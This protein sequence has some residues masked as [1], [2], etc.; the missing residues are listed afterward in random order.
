MKNSVIFLVGV[1]FLLNIFQSKA[2][3]KYKWS[4]NANTGSTMLWGDMADNENPFVKMFSDQSKLSFG[5]TVDRQFTNYLGLQGGFLYARLAGQRTLWSN[6]KPA[7]LGFEGIGLD[8]YIAPTLDFTGL[9]GA[10]EDR[11]ISIYIFGGVGQVHYQSEKM[12]IA[13]DKT[14]NKVGFNGRQSAITIPWGGGVKLRLNDRFKIKFENSYRNLFVDDIDAHIGSGTNVNDIYS[15][16]SVGLDYRFNIPVKREPQIEIEPIEKDTAIAEIDTVEVY[17]PVKVMIKNQLPGEIENGKEYIASIK[18]DKGS[19][20]DNAKLSITAPD[21]FKIEEIES[22]GGTF[23][24]SMGKLV[25]NWDEF[26]DRERLDIKYKLKTDDVQANTYNFKG[27]LIY[28]EQ[29]KEKVKQFESSLK[30]KAAEIIAQD[31][32]D[33]N[34]SVENDNEN[35]NSDVDVFELDN[36]TSAGIEFR[37]QVAA[38]YGGKLNTP[39]FK[40]RNNINS[41]IKEDFFKGYYMYSVGSYTEYK[42]ALK[43]LDAT[44]VRGAYVVVFKDGKRIHH[45]YDLNADVMD[46]NALN[47]NGLTYKIQISASRGKPYSIIKLAHKYNFDSGEIYEDIYSR[48]YQYSLGEFDNMEEAKEALSKVKAENGVKDAFIV[49]FRNGKRT[50]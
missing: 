45:L 13:N 49:K 18:I 23:S 28:S 19:L 11:L 31:T 50:R 46:K 17:Q 43:R 29:D 39:I 26:P 4:V 2:Q 34:E 22:E 44:N 10:P 48:W 20:H 8:Y 7:N 41:E 42:D 37:V 35:V 21:G 47:P 32:D 33:Q 1:V 27:L 40:E 12:D 3:D 5:V 14:L 6:D 24:F 30:V 9:F 36:N 25:I 16:T 38:V 15:Y